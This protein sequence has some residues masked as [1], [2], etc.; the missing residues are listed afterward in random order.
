MFTT[1]KDRQLM[2]APLPIYSKDSGIKMSVSSDLLGI[3]MYTGEHIPTIKGKNGVTY[4][5]FN[6]IALETQ[7]YPNSVNEGIKNA[8]FKRPV[9][10]AGETFKSVTE[11][12]FEN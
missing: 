10:K 2:N 1:F 11:Y 9:V 12:K 4:D 7:C 3:Q 6:G 8:A 5:S